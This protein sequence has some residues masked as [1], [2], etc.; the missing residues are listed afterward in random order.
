ML[1]TYPNNNIEHSNVY[2][3]LLFIHVF[4]VVGKILTRA[5]NDSES[6]SRSPAF[7]ST[8]NHSTVKYQVFPLDKVAE[9]KAG[10]FGSLVTRDSR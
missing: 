5:I 2:L 1:R 4:T 3:N 7:I 8:V 10:E 6:S 9:V